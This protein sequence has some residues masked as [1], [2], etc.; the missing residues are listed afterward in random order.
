MR[1]VLSGLIRFYGFFISP[2]FGRSCRYHPSCSAYALQALEC[3]GAL[4]GLVLA[5]L[6]ILRCH[7]WARRRP[8]DPVPE[9]FAWGDLFRYKRGVC[10]ESHEK[11]YKEKGPLLR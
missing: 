7:P 1:P 6:R 9:A 10:S 2:L 11:I 3:H 8:R 4:K 5:A